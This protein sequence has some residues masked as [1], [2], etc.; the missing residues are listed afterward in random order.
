[1]S[2][3]V[4]KREFY[5]DQSNKNNRI[6]LDWD[7]II[8]GRK[9]LYTIKKRKDIWISVEDSKKIITLPWFKKK[10]IFN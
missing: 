2:I 10:L 9:K 4:I 5:A 6:K 3:K 1:M 7:F 8:K